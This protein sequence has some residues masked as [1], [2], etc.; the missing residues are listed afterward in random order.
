[1]NENKRQEK[2]E[3]NMSRNKKERENWRKTEGNKYERKGTEWKRKRKRKKWEEKEGAVLK[4]NKENRKQKERKNRTEPQGGKE[5]KKKSY[6]KWF[7]CLTFTAI[8]QQTQRY[9]LL[10]SPKP[11]L[12]KAKI[13][14]TRLR[15][16]LPNNNLRNEITASKEHGPSTPSSLSIHLYYMYCA[17]TGERGVERMLAEKI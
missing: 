15:I 1:M 16:F 10:S 2:S 17:S 4:K 9:R 6:I 7:W 14:S 3:K 12:A 8:S 11:V 13:P 5:G